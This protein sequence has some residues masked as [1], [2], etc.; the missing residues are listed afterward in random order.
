MRQSRRSLR[1]ARVRLFKRAVLFGPLAWFC[2][3]CVGSQMLFGVNLIESF[4]RAWIMANIVFG[5]LFIPCGGAVARVL[6]SHC[7]QSSRWKAA[8]DGISGRSL[9]SAQRDLER[10]TAFAQESSIEPC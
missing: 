2:G 1:R 9:I 10:W 7:N 3:M 6:A 8:L 5:V 4:D